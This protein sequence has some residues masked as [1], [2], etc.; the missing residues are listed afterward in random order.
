MKYILIFLTFIVIGCVPA[1]QRYYRAVACNRDGCNVLEE[2][3]KLTDCLDLLDNIHKL[4]ESRG[5]MPSK[6]TFCK[7]NN[8]E[9][10]P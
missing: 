10:I 8:G 3:P 6:V 9:V 4:H 1:Q 2:F 7:D 5:D